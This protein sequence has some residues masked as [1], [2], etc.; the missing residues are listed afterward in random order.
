MKSTAK[1]VILAEETPIFNTKLAIE[2]LSK[3]HK[4]VKR[5]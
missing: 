2:T 5:E 4:Q 3:I 1:S